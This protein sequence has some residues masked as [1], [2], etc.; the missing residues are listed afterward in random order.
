MNSTEHDEE[1]SEEETP[2]YRL[3][4]SCWGLVLFV[5]GFFLLSIF[6]LYFAVYIESLSIWNPISLPS[7]C[8]IVSSS[9]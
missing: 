8:K 3:L 5:L 9:K 4:R 2:N 1:N 7:R 6:V